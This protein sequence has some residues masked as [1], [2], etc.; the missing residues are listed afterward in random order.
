MDAQPHAWGWLHDV[1]NNLVMGLWALGGA[2]MRG[3][4]DWRDNDGAI[5]PWRIFAGLVTAF[6]LGQIAISAGVWWHVADPIVG[7]LAGIMGWLGPK[8]TIGFVTGVGDA[9]KRKR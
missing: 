1:M 2:V 4:T 8:A 9:L 5:S 7:G 3:D 6:V